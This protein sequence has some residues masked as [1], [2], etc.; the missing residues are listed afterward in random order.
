MIICVV[1]GDASSVRFMSRHV[2]DDSFAGGLQFG[3]L[4]KVPFFAALDNLS[5]IQI[6]SR[7]KYV[8]QRPIL[9]LDDGSRSNF[10]MREGHRG[11]E[12]CKHF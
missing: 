1:W 4:H 8:V 3:I 7:L 2:F 9:K 12:V 6:C 11:T 5:C 10:I